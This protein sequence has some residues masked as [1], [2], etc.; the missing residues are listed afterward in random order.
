MKFFSKFFIFL[1][2]TCATIFSCS[3]DPIIEIEICN[4]N[5][6][7]DGDGL[8]DCDDPDCQGD[9]DCVVIATEICNNNIDDD[10]D[11]LVDCDDPNCQFEANCS[12]S[13]EWSEVTTFNQE[14]QE[15]KVFD[16]KLFIT[17]NFTERENSNSYWSTFLSN[18]SF[19]NH[20][21]LIGGSG[22]DELTIFDGELYGAGFLNPT[23]SSP[24]VVKWNG[25][26]W[27]VSGPNNENQNCIYT[28]GTTL[29]VGS[30]FGKVSHRTTNS[31]WETYPPI[32]DE[33][34]TSAIVKFE[35]EI[36]VGGDCEGGIHKWDG[37][38]WS[39]LGG[40]TEGTV[41]KL[42][43]FNDKL[44][45]GGGFS[46]IGGQ[47]IVDLAVWDGSSWS[48]LGGSVSHNSRNGIRD[49]IEYNNNLFVVGDFTEIGGVEAKY[50]ARWDG[51]NWN[52]MNFEEGDSF[53]DYPNCIEIY[54]NKIFIG[55]GSFDV[56]HLYSLD[57]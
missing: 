3:D 15:L 10:G 19:T 28:D 22:I 18:N 34:F 57:L 29:Y 11:G 26:S 8:V 25:S 1:L 21:T 14:V 40:G 20:T 7:D 53:D 52:S 31:S 35:N 12:T 27:D 17:G 13:L 4:N 55:T 9:P 23:S 24:G 51:T 56:A 42:F 47:D 5:I 54:N 44:I 45:V 33:R 48:S 2:F 36:I 37:N 46:Q 49:M 39:A 6:D 41:R 16:N 38:S 30:G 50:I 32:T 43:I